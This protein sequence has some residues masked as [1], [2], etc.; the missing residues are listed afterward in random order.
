VQK[1]S[2]CRFY[3]IDRFKPEEQY[4]VTGSRLDQRVQ[5]GHDLII[6]SSSHSIWSLGQFPTGSPGYLNPGHQKVTRFQL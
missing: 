6:G 3:N 1:L 4:Q 2:E 5:F